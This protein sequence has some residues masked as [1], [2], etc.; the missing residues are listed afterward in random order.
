MQPRAQAPRARR[1]G[2]GG[3][4]VRALASLVGANRAAKHGR[5]L[6]FDRATEHRRVIDR[7]RPEIVDV[8]VQHD[9]ARRRAAAVIP[10]VHIVARRDE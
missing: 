7:G 8:E 1:R 2:V 4:V 3:W 10:L 6:R 9:H 5:V